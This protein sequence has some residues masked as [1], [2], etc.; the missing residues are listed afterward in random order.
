MNQTERARLLFTLLDAADD[1][2]RLHNPALGERWQAL[3]QRFDSS[4]SEREFDSE[5][6]L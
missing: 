3:K 1:D 6:R 2:G 5:D 4:R